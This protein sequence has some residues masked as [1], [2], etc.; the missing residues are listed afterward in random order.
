MK[1]AMIIVSSLLALAALASAAGKLRKS[2]Q[3]IE[4]MTHV[5]V[6][7]TQVPLLAWLEIAGGVGLLAGLA[8]KDVGRLAAAGLV[9][10]FAGAV[11]AHLRIKDKVAAFAPALFLFLISVA[12]LVLQVGR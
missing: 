5:G 2:P 6:A 3:V 8:L 1:I 10:Y 12:A 11:V 7:E 9:V 4:T